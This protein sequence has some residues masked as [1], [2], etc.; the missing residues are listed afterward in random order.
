MPAICVGESLSP[1]RMFAM[2]PDVG[3]ARSDR[4]LTIQAGERRYADV[5]EKSDAAPNRQMAVI[6]ETSR[7]E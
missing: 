1:K 5:L 4:R 6:H 3:M 2:I 7:S